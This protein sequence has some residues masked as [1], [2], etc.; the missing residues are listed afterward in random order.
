MQWMVD[1][2]LLNL[3]ADA[4]DS[5][6]ALQVANVMRVARSTR[7]KERYL[8]MLT[9]MQSWVLTRLSLTDPP[10]RPCGDGDPPDF[11]T[12]SVWAMSVLELLLAVV[13]HARNGRDIHFAMDAVAGTGSLGAAPTLAEGREKYQ[14]LA[15]LLIG[16]V[17]QLTKGDPQQQQQPT[18][19]EA[20]AEETRP[21][22]GA[23]G[24]AGS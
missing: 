21:E 6:F 3:A 12:V 14:R 24:K 1:R 19:Q 18:D 16:M 5:S 9:L 22:T 2:P 7:P 17:N 23:A 15:R 4:I 13:R 8:A 10:Q 20:A 11:E